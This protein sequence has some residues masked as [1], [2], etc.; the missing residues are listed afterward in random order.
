MNDS[1][2]DAKFS[3]SFKLSDLKAPANCQEVS[4]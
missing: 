3:F 1:P 4:Y 2:N